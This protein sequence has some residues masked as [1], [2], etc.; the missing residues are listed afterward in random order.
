MH[1]LRTMCWKTLCGQRASVLKEK[2]CCFPWCHLKLLPV[3]MENGDRRTQKYPV[4]EKL[5][6]QL[7]NF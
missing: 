2:M 6:I 3:N 5:K 1:P 7:I 4:K